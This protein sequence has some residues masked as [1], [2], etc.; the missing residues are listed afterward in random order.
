M[1][2]YGSIAPKS[3]VGDMIFLSGMFEYNKNLYRK[4]KS[5]FRKGI[6]RSIK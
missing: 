1:R 4:R 2:I 5:E 6:V 3:V